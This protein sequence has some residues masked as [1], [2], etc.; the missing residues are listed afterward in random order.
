LA[1]IKFEYTD[2]SSNLTLNISNTGA[3]PIY[4]GGVPIGTGRIKAGYSYIFVFDGTHYILISALESCTEESKLI[5]YAG[6]SVS[7]ERT[8]EI[9]N[10]ISDNEGWDR[11][12]MVFD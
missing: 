3:A 6:L 2:G 11:A 10:T 1:I 7:P 8:V 12:V 4:S 5:T 9:P